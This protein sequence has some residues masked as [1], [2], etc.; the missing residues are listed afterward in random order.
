VCES[1]HY[2]ESKYFSQTTGAF[3]RANAIMREGNDTKPGLFVSGFQL[4]SNGTI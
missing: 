1:L 4:G 2:D 3:Y